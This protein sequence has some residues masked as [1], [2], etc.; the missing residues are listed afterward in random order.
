MINRHI[1]TSKRKESALDYLLAI[2]LAISG[3]L[4]LLHGLDAL[5]Y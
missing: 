1:F 5:F 4:L 2:L 3:A